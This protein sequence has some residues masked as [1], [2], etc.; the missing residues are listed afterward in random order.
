MQENNDLSKRNVNH[1]VNATKL[2]DYYNSLRSNVMSILG[3]VGMPNGPVSAASAGLAVAASGANTS[4]LSTSHMTGSSGSS[5][6]MPDNIS[7]ENFDSYLSK[8]QTICTEN[9]GE[10]GVSNSGGGG[11]IPTHH[12]STGHSGLGGGIPASSSSKQPVMYDSVKSALQNFNALS[13]R[14]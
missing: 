2:N 3:H 1:N 4:G 9:M 14:I 12:N 10:D 13:T 7:Q 6:I 5:A 11:G 8:L